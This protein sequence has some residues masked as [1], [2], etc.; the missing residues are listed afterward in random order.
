[1]KKQDKIITETLN[2]AIS[3]YTKSFEILASTMSD[4]VN[5]MNKIDWDGINKLLKDENRKR[6][7]PSR[8]ETR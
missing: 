4:V 7:E 5:A 1:M 2:Q 8:P 6:Q 3:A